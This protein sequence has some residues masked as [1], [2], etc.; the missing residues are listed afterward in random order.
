[1]K[2]PGCDKKLRAKYVD[3]DYSDKC[4]IKGTILSDIKEYTCRVCNENYHDLGSID[5]I[6]HMI[7]D[8]LLNAF[9]LESSHIK[10]IRTEIFNM[11]YFQFAKIIQCDPDL[12]RDVESRG[13]KVTK[14]F[15]DSVKLQ[16]LKKIKTPRITM[17]S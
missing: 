10:F 8:I 4:G 13:A 17:G 12:I 6:N 16:L 9:P 2:C 1:M 11:T 3:F 7:G 14:R 5:E 15:R